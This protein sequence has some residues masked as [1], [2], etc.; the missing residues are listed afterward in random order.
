MR[1]RLNIEY[2]GSA[3]KGWQLQKG[4]ITVQGEIEHALK[5]IFS[6][7]VGIIGAGRTDTGVHARGQVAH[8]DLEHP[9][10]PN[11]LLRSLNGILQNDIRIKEVSLVKPDFH[12]RYSAKFREYHYCISPQP[13]AMLRHFTWHL[14][15]NLDLNLLNQAAKYILGN[16]DFTSFCR[17]NSDV[18]NHFCNVKKAEWLKKDDLIIFIIQADRF[19][20]GM[21]RALVGTFVDIGRNKLTVSDMK[22]IL[23]DKNRS[24]ASQSAPAR[25]LIL[26]KV[27]Y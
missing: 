2:D 24:S 6:D 11:I 4:Q 1:F 14:T 9:T 8:F 21:V 20:H 27:F 10:D 18:N 15:Y 16:I 12:A 23:Q 7:H 22:T 19:L 26:E 25:G 3:Y 17:K 5:Q 13:V